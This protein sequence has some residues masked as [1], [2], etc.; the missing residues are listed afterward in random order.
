VDF[1]EAELSVP[2]ALE[3]L[4]PGLEESSR[5]EQEPSMA[6]RFSLV[7]F[8]FDLAMALIKGLEE[9]NGAVVTDVDLRPDGGIV[10]HL[11][12][13]AAGRGRSENEH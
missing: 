11:A 12:V 2:F 6:Q 9:R 4:G 8:P 13:P 5:P 7:P 10:V 1:R 3:G